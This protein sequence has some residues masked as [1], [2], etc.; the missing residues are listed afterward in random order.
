MIRDYTS[1]SSQW[2]P[3]DWHPEKGYQ[4]DLPKN[5]YPRVAK[6]EGIANG[7]SLILNGDV[8]DYYCSST[9]GAGF[10]VSPKN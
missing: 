9:N 2:V 3:V 7:L 10:K 4:Q 1:L 6:G 8:N 5:F